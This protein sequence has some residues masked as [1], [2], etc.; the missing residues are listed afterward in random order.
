MIDASLR[1]LGAAVFA[2]ATAASI[3]PLAGAEDC[4]ADW[5]AAGEVVRRE[6]LRTVEDLAAAEKEGKIVK[7]TLC[8]AVGGYVYRLVIRAPDGHLKATV[9]PAQGR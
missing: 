5:G 7:S 1:A 6:K 3:P 4:F 9:V 2:V 8:L